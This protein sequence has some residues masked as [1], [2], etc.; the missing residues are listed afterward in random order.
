MLGPVLIA[1][2]VGFVVAAIWLWT[3]HKGALV[4]A[5]SWLSYAGY[6]FLM[7]RRILCTGECN[8]RVDL[9]LLYPALLLAS[10]IIVGKALADVIR[11]R[12]RS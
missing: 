6:E 7:Y 2:A 3:R 1:L 9:L 8:I 5:I 12:R 4:L 10:M 11:S